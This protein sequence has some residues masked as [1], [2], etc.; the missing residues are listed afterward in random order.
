MVYAREDVESVLAARG[1]REIR[2]IGEGSF[3]KALLVEAAD[4][5]QAVCK[6]MDISEASRKEAEDA[7]KEGRLLASLQHP[8]VVRYRDSFCEAGVLCLIMDFCEG[9]ELAKQ[10]RRARRNHQRIPEEQ[11]L[12]WFTQAMLSLKYIHDKH[13]LHRDLKPANFFLTKTGS[14]KMGDFGIAK[15]MACTIAFAKTRIG[16]PYYLSPE[17]CQEKPYAWAS[18]MWSMGCILYEMCALQVPFDAHSISGLV[19]KICYGPLPTVPDC[20]SDFLRRLCRQLLDRDPK[21]RP[22]ADEVLQ[23]PEIQKVVRQML[24]EVR[25][26]QREDRR[27]K[28]SATAGAYRKDDVVEYYSVTHGEWLPATIVDADSMGRVMIDL[29][30]GVWLSPEVQASKIRPREGSSS[31]ESSGSQEEWRQPGKVSDEDASK[32]VPAVDSVPEPLPPRVERRKAP[33]RLRDSPRPPEEPRPLRAIEVPGANY[34][35]L[36]RLLGEKAVRPVVWRSPSA[37]A[38]DR[39]PGPIRRAPSASGLASRGRRPAA[40]VPLDNPP[41]SRAPSSDSCRAGTPPTRPGSGDGEK[42]SL[43]TPNAPGSRRRT[44]MG[45]KSRAHCLAA[46]ARAAGRV[47]A[48]A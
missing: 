14:L 26:L 13:I 22:S 19:Q 9:G 15:T 42:D 1:W 39:Q 36:D 25:S 38:I 16:T 32:A 6:V 28:T 3:A 4:G 45:V 35:Q 41:S 37:G 20:Y 30:P 27:A 17:V 23:L 10:I 7:A 31:D 2:Q 18:D 12:R 34:D 5:T 48:G 29:R 43:S 8:F 24:E 46:A 21:K 11:I 44:P 33:L 47:I 40:L